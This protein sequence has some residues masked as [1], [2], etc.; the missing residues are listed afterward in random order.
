[1][2]QQ[3]AATTITVTTAVITPAS[4]RPYRPSYPAYGAYGYRGYGPNAVIV[5]RYITP[6]IVTVVPYRPYAY[7]P[8][9]GLGVYYGTNGY[10]YGYTPRGLLRS[11]A[12]IFLRRPAY[13]RRAASR[14]GLR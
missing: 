11:A 1:M 7:R 2:E 8:R 13:H 3:R 5:P 4:I 9:L 6:R 14:A 12:G 10:P